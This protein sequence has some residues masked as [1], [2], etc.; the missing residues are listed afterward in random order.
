M[1]NCARLAAV[2]VGLL[3]GPAA[4][5]AAETVRVSGLQDFSCLAPADVRLGAIQLEGSVVHRAIDATWITLKPISKWGSFS[6][7]VSPEDTANVGTAIADGWRAI[8]VSSGSDILTLR[9]EVV[10]VSEGGREWRGDFAFGEKTQRLKFILVENYVRGTDPAPSLRNVAY[11]PDARQVLD[12]YRADSASPTPV[13]LFIHGGSWIR[14]DKADI[15]G[16]RDFLD[17]GISVVSISYRYCPPTNPSDEEPAVAIPLRDAARALQF[18]RSK[19]AE[20][21]VDGQRI[22]VW[23]VSAGA[24]SAL[25]L[26][27]HPDLADPAGDAV[28]RESTRPLCAAG[29]YP[30]TTLDPEEMRQWVGEGIT[31]GAHAFGLP[32]AETPGKRFELFLAARPRLKPWIERYSPSALLSSDDPPIFLDYLD[33]SLTPNE[34]LGA[35]YTHSP[36]FGVGFAQRAKEIGAECHVGF[37]GHRDLI[38]PDWRTFLIHMLTR[39]KST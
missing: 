24:C 15:V 28:S 25:W 31:Y 29:A 12:F 10:A 22:G 18:V 5:R 34:P 4:N 30:Q 26:A 16:V 11:G 37:A 19:A 39:S 2:G 17:A 20:W 14:G 35:Y 8:R 6:Y 1:W 21:K 23:G 38:Y 27:T 32:A 7:R 13:A 33:F 3:I 36:G 9:G